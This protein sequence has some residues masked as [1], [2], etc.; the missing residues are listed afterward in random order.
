MRNLILKSM[1]AR[2][3]LA[4]ALA[5]FADRRVRRNPAPDRNSQSDAFEEID[6]YVERQTE[7]LNVPGAAIAIVEGDEIAHLR[8]FGRASPG[9]EAPTPETPFIIGSLTKSFTALA[10]MQL[11]ADGMVELDPRFSATYPGSGSLTPR[12]PP[13]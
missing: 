4:L 8:G 12:H 5:L 13:R 7:R 10:V 11:V 9:G 6:A 1:A 3:V 2:G